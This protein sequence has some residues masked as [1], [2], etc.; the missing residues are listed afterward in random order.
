MTAFSKKS[1]FATVI[2]IQETYKNQQKNQND[3]IFILNVNKQSNFVA[4]NY[5]FGF[6]DVKIN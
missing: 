6:H 4:K 2:Q 3:F 5:H 1:N